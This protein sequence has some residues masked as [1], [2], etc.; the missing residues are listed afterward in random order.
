MGLS[1]PK[2]SPH[3]SLPRVY[4]SPARQRFQHFSTRRLKAV[5]K[6]KLLDRV[7]A[8]ARVRHLSLRTEQAYSDCIRRFILFHKKRHPEQMGSEE[9]RQFLSHL[10]V[11]GHVSAST[12]NV[13]LC[14]LLFLYRDVLGMELPYVEGI[15]RA[16]RPVRV[17]VVFTR[18]EAEGLLRRLS[19][20]YALIAGL[21]Y[22]S[23]LRLMEAVRLRVKDLDFE[24]M[25]ILVRDGKGEKDRRTIL[26]RPLSEPLRHQLERVR[27]LH[28]QDLREGFGE[29]YLPYALARK[30]PSAA[31]A[32]AWQ[33]VFPS[34]KLSVDPRS[35]VT[36][37]HHA[38][39]DSVQRE[40]K[41]AIRLAAIT[42]HG[43]CHTLRHSFAT[44]LLEDGYDLR[45]I[46]ELLGHSDV[47]TTQIYTHVLNK[48]GRGVR[49]PL[50]S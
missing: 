25:E 39:A 37:R 1:K 13:A 17:P 5:Q 14:A 2:H 48:G 32:W 41:R 21:L 26:P 11:E 10:A 28:E 33:Y 22:G 34:A 12:Q 40:V 8:V 23:G 49:S 35:G 15:Q 9:I 18:R 44:H 42:K 20:T 30:Y 43:G 46:Q 50:E 27:L 19:G 3:D 7:R 4:N 6:P 38:S 45:T 36:R 16:K 47:R 24:Y 31:R 29:V